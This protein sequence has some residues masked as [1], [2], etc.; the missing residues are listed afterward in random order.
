[1]ATF[2]FDVVSEYDKGEMNHAFDQARREMTNR[3]DFK[4][5][6]AAIDWL[7]DKNGIKVTGA[8]EWQI[9]SVIDI[10]RKKLAMRS[11]ST[12]VLDESKALVEGN[13]KITKEIPFKRGLDQDKAK[14]IT[15]LLREK[16]PKVKAQIQGEAVRVSSSKKDELQAAM[17]VIREQNFDFPIEFNNYR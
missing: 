2:S 17:N 4:D 5:T 7:A 8:S 12:K 16:L 3:Y 1:M 6:P 11:Q 9:D 10:F 15:K 14:S 13:M